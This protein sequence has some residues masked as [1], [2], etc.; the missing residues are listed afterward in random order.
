MLS[1][2][3]RRSY[4][5]VKYGQDGHDP[6]EWRGGECAAVL[7]P[8][9]TSEDNRP[10]AKKCRTIRHRISTSCM[11][12]SILPGPYADDDVAQGLAA[13][14]HDPA[15]LEVF[16]IDVQ[17]LQVPLAN[18][19]VVIVEL[20]LQP[21]SGTTMA[22]L[23]AFMMLLMSPVRPRENSVMGISSEMPPPAAVPLTFMVGPPEG[24]RMQP[25]TFHARLPRPSIKPMEV[26]GFAFAQ[27]SG[28]DGGD[29]DVS[30]VGVCSSGGSGIFMSVNAADFLAVGDA[31]IFGDFQLVAHRVKRD[32]LRFGYFGNLPVFL[33]NRIILRHKY[34][35]L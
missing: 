31:L 28:G 9:W 34:C 35:L 19:A 13:V 27:G 5:E 4:R 24:W 22:R 32:H 30:A 29:F 16:G 2:R 33:F 11:K 15:H 7:R 12:P 17:A 6:K 3:V 23:W 26:V 21:G 10:R 20:M 1:G 25:P 14:V 18:W 8:V